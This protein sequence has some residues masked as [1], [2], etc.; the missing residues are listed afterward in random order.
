[1]DY[2][3]HVVAIG[4]VTLLANSF[5]KIYCEADTG[6]TMCAGGGGRTRRELSL[7]RILSC[8]IMPKNCLVYWLYFPLNVKVCKFLCKYRRKPNNIG[9][10]HLCRFEGFRHCPYFRC[11]KYQ[12]MIHRM[13]FLTLGSRSKHS[14]LICR[15]KRRTSMRRD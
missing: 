2:V 9:R 13:R 7:Q 5:L 3:T 14:H 11:V 6:L 12:I 4:G 15:R 10:L 1:M 8:L